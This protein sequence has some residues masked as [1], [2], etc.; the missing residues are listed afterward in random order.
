V[1]EYL[2]L[3]T[4][5][6][7]EEIT[8]YLAAH[9]P[10]PLAERLDV[11]DGRVETKLATG[12]HVHTTFDEMVALYRLVRDGP[13]HYGSGHETNDTPEDLLRS[14][15]S[16]YLGA[17]DQ[18]LPLPRVLITGDVLDDLDHAVV[19]RRTARTQSKNGTWYYRPIRHGNGYRARCPNDTGEPFRALEAGF[20]W[21]AATNHGRKL[22]RCPPCG[23]IL[24]LGEYP[25]PY[26]EELHRELTRTGT[27]HGTD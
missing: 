27:E 5:L 3:R 25:T 12:H 14:R 13:F 2:D 23:I 10:A 19:W 8:D 9:V 26:Y 1:G 22:Y 21:D 7:A 24:T 16:L 20:A 6:R 4:N 17:L 15:A 18:G 11:G